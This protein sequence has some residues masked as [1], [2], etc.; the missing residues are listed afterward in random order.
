MKMQNL[1]DFKGFE[2]RK[3]LNFSN[4]LNFTKKLKFIRNLNL[5]SVLLCALLLS[6]C[7]TKESL[8]LYTLKASA[9][10]LQALNTTPSAKNLASLKN[11]S[12]KILA[13]QSTL[14]LKSENI[15]YIK[16][17]EFGTYSQH[18]FSGAPVWLFKQNL[19]YKFESAHLFK[20]IVSELSLLKT[21]FVLESS[22]ENFEQI[23]NEKNQSVVKISANISLLK[24]KALL[25][26]RFFTKEIA[27]KGFGI[28]PSIKA[29]EEALNAL[30]D[31][32][33]KW[34]IEQ[35]LSE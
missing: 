13:P 26:Q 28:D 9:P 33:F 3:N 4:R 8:A 7:G 18:A 12:L 35:I 31:E 34:V 24:D 6:A 17:N 19:M 14:Y 29:F 30:N 2:L 20:A 25:S 22:L 21:D 11:F 10:H 27:S 32:I 1:L 15:S 16:G 5:A 23:F